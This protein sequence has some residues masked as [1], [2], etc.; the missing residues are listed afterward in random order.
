MY[1]YVE[2]KQHTLVQ[3]LGYRGNDKGNWK[4][5]WNE[6]KLRHNTQKVMGCNKS[7][8]QREFHGC[9]SLH[10]KERKMWN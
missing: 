6:W 3:P 9:E 2:V 5:L 1:E 7:S 8:A 4:I 10:Y